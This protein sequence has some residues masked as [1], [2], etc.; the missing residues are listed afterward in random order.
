V[1]GIEC[2]APLTLR[3]LPNRLDAAD[4]ERL[5]DGVEFHAV[6]LQCS[7]GA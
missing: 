7:F 5:D 4:A 2:S 3:S 6:S 1:R